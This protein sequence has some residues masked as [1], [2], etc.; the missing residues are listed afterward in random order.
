MIPTPGNTEYENKLLTPHWQAQFTLPRN[1]IAGLEESN[2]YIDYQG[3]RVISLNAIRMQDDQAGWL[4]QVLANNPNRW[5]VV[6][7]HFPFY[8]LRDDREDNSYL[9]RHWKPVFDKYGIDLALN[10]HDHGYAR[11]H[12]DH[13]T[14]YVCSVAGGEDAR[15]RA[16]ALDGPG[17]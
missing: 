12:L 8:T 7:Y 4:E 11:S 13:S 17:R 5:T 3:V 15:G 1:G 10:G 14:V 2:Y 16:P 6:T 9:K